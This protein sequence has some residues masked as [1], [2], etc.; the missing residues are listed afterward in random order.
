MP[1]HLY[2]R[3]GRYSDA[4]LSNQH[5]ILADEEYI[6]QCRAQ[7]LYPLAYFPHN[8]HFLWFAATFEGRSRTAIEA[9]RKAASKIS[10]EDMRKLPFLQCFVA[11]PYYALT[12]FGKWE[13][14]LKEPRPVKDALYLTGV[15]RYARGTALTAT[16]KLGAAKAELESLRKI[17]SDPSLADMPASFSSNRAGAILAVAVESLAGEFAAKKKDFDKALAHLERAARLEDALI[18]T[19][20][21]DWHYPVS[22]SLAAVLLEAGR[23]A[24][25]EVVYWEDLR[26]NPENGW[27]LFGL[28][29]SLRAQKKTDEAAAIEKRFRK[30]WANADVTLSSSRFN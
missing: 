7:G 18:Y 25:A 16:G 20:P 19:E 27:S 13:E 6:T 2:V 15:W 22:Q 1:S 24:E 30:A 29:Q 9:A 28:M 14:I 5:A 11:V 3:V 8:I 12:R 10:P 23:A 21:A 17:A 4:S 26:R